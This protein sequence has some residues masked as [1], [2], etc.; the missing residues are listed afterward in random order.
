MTNVVSVKFNENGRIYYFN[1]DGVQYE[2]GARVIVETSRGTELG[3]VARS[4]FDVP[5]E[6][7]VQPLRSVIREA[8]TMDIKRC[9]QS[10]E[11]NREVLE[12]ARARVE[13]F[14]LPMKLIAAEHSFDGSKITFFFTADGRVD[15]RELVKDLR[16]VFYPTRVELQQVGVRDEA[17]M[18]GG[19]GFC[20][21]EFC[22]KQFLRSF[23]PVSIKMA[24]TQGLSLNP[25]KISGSCGRLMCCLQY[26]DEAYQEL[27]SRAPK[28]DSFVETPGGK[29]TI[30]NV[31]LL[32]S[33]VKV[34][35]ED[36]NDTQL[37]TFT[38]DELDVLGGKARRAEYQAAKAEGRL[39]EAG[40]KESVIVKPKAP[41]ALKTA[42]IQQ[43]PIVKRNASNRDSGPG[44]QPAAETPAEPRKTETIPKPERKEK[45]HLPKP[46]RPNAQFTPKPPPKPS[47]RPVPKQSPKPFARPSSPRPE[48]ITRDVYDDDM[49]IDDEIG[50]PIRTPRPIQK[51]KK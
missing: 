51:H 17:R 30:I 11:Q 26:E 46:Q 25:L 23:H 1:P 36:G 18:F 34:R 4:N 13:E 24:K 8:G 37:K 12:K 16:L 41:N 20:G 9:E 33:T 32:R 45:R 10:R 38:F 5:D 2:K 39:E 48:R 50:V 49:D 3:I 14:N 47:P 40:F 43:K 19:L 44:G 35:L 42:P 15:F 7:I 22:C 27:V 31:N 21:K 6:D 28:V 29:G